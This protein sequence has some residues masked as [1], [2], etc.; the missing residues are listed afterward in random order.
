[1]KKLLL[2]SLFAAACGKSSAKT[3]KPN[4][5]EIMIT[6]QVPTAKCKAPE[7]VSLCT[8]DNQAI[9]ISVKDGTHPWKVLPYYEPPATDAGVGSGSATPTSAGSAAGSS[10]TTPGTGSAGNGSAG[11]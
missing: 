2:V 11:K 5:S 4:V 9:I 6:G 8:L 3:D 10:S 1:M 7:S